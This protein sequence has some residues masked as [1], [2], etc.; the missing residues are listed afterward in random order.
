MPKTAYTIDVKGLGEAAKRF[1]IAAEAAEK[2]ANKMVKV[3]NTT[4]RTATKLGPIVRRFARIGTTTVRA[5]SVL[6]SMASGL[7]QVG[8]AALRGAD[9]VSSLVKSVTE[10]TQALFDFASAGEQ[11]SQIARAF[12]RLGGTAADMKALREA[13][14]GMVDDTTLQQLANTANTL[15]INKDQFIQLSE[16]A[17]AASQAMGIDAK[18]AMESIM[19]GT[20]RL[21]GPLLDNVGIV[22]KSGAAY[23]A[24]AR[25]IGKV[26]GSALSDFEKKQAFVNAVVESGNDLIGKLG[27]IS[28]NSFAQ[29]DA[30]IE[31][32]KSEVQSTMAEMLKSSGAFEIMNG[33]LGKLKVLFE[34][35]KDKIQELISKALNALPGLLD[36]AVKVG[37]PLLE[38]MS[39]NAETIPLAT[40]ALVLLVNGTRKLLDVFRELRPSVWSLLGPFKSLASGATLAAGAIADLTGKAKTLD[41]VSK[42]VRKVR[43]DLSAPPSGPQIWAGDALARAGDQIAAKRIRFEAEGRE[44]AKT[45]QRF[46]NTFR[47]IGISISNAQY[48]GENGPV[49]SASRGRSQ[50]KTYDK[51][52]AALGQFA[53]GFASEWKRLGDMQRTYLRLAG[54]D[55]D[56]QMQAIRDKYA[57]VLDHM[58]RHGAEAQVIALEAQ[59]A[60]EM[61][62]VTHQETVALQMDAMTGRM[63]ALQEA[64]Q[65]FSEAMRE[66]AESSASLGDGA[67]DQHSALKALMDGMERMQGTARSFGEAIANAAM[68]GTSATQA[69]RDAF[70]SMFYDLAEG[71]IA[72]AVAQIKGMT[73]PFVGLAAA[74]ALRF[75]SGMVKSAIQGPKGGGGG[76]KTQLPGQAIDRRRDSEDNEGRNSQQSITYNMYGYAEPPEMQGSTTRA[77]ARGARR[78]LPSVRRGNTKRLGRSAAA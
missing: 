53:D 59:Q 67:G 27:G 51:M 25:K 1:D 11:A 18:S 68:T 30:S 77:S 10:A 15:G 5:A 42:G 44:L 47:S 17:M 4:D 78:S 12:E 2:F 6:P 62:A 46:V 64:A 32:F 74:I 52:L 61:F 56:V 8:G 49:E 45:G 31:N 58:R 9:M 29:M 13:T 76:S 38:L 43:E 16:A 70:G 63:T 57:T 54:S 37:V 41:A 19:S 36:A 7:L 72:L 22:V 50:E 14:R 55:A 69:M 71:F 48:W 66:A 34:E 65:G 73:N 26:S 60:L 23:D 75:A 35:N 40:D 24:Y 28:V 33:M 21:S 3:A 39:E 20:A